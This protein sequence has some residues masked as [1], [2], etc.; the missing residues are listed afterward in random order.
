MDAVR[1][2]DVV[3]LGGAFS[4][5]SAAHPA[6][7]RAAATSRVLIVEKAEAFD[8]KVGEATTEMSAMFLTRRLAHVAAPRE[9]AA[10]EGGAAL[11]VLERAR[12]PATPTPARPAAS[13]AAPCPRSSSAAT[14]STS[15]CWPPPSPRA[16]SCG[17][18]RGCATSSSA[19]STTGSRSRRTARTRDRRLP[20]GA[21]RHRPRHLPR[22]APRARSSATRST[23]PPR[24]GAAGRTSAT[25]TTSRPAGR[26]RSRRGNVSSRRLATNHYMGFGYWIWVIPLGNGETSIGVVFDT[27]ARRPR[28]GREPARRLPRLPARHPGA[29]RAARGRASCAART[30]AFYSHLPYV[31][32]PV[33]GRRL[34]AARRRRG[35]PRSL[36]L[37]GARP[38]L[39]HRRGDGGDRQGP[40]ATGEDVA[41]RIA[42]HNETFLRSYWRFFRAVYKDKYFYMGEHDLL[43]GRRSSSTPRSTTSSW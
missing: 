39:V 35:V 37:A 13:S 24:S 21:R 29:R 31:T 1:R 12:S 3:V 6:A 43:V 27:R 30:C 25:S 11:L 33:H 16:P 26:C 28:P 7:P 34:G 8:E 32:T 18:R 41:A 9:R 40:D 15:T 19:T 20:L 23:P 42:E 22:Q 2:Y 38:R 4:G 10:P 36:L 5:A 14:R 17:G